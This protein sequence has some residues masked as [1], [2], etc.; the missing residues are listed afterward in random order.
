M[1]LFTKA[2]KVKA[3]VEN[4]PGT[5]IKE[6]D[7]MKNLVKRYN[8]RY[9]IVQRNTLITG[10]L[11]CIPILLGSVKWKLNKYQSAM[12]LIGSPLTIYC[13]S[14]LCPLIDFALSSDLYIRDIMKSG[15][16]LA[17]VFKE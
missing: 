5:S 15:L 4:Y 9:K 8:Y 17:E 11:V 16:P 2:W 7:F 6:K 10:G 13:M 12:L 14:H 3:F 1:V